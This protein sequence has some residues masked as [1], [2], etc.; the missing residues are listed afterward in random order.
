MYCISPAQKW[1]FHC[2]LSL[3]TDKSSKV[4]RNKL[5]D[6]FKCILVVEYE[7]K[8]FRSPKSTGT[9]LVTLPVKYY[10][11]IRLLIRVFL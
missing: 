6:H 7:G 8:L 9:L 1:T 3:V 5:S 10:L 2:L 11:T 4:E